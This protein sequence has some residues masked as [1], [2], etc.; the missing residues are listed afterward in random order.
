MA[1]VYGPWTGSVESAW[2]KGRVVIW[3]EHKS[4]EADG[5]DQEAFDAFV[6]GFTLTEKAYEKALSQASGVTSKATGEPVEA[7]LFRTLSKFQRVNR[8]MHKA[9]AQGR[10]DR[11]CT[12]A[13][14]WIRYCY[15]RRPEHGVFLSRKGTQVSFVGTKGDIPEAWQIAY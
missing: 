5:L 3:F 14:A 7:I 9:L 13:L 4:Y 10:F 8:A 15:V 1:K 2:E 12:L 6:E 11:F